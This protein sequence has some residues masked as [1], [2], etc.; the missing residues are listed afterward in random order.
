VTSNVE[1]AKVSGS[2]GARQ[3]GR[4]IWWLIIS[5]LF[6]VLLGTRFWLAKKLSAPKP[7]LALPAYTLTD[8][9]GKPFGAADLRGKAYIADFVFTSCPSVCPR[10]TKRMV[11]VQNRT[12]DLGDALYL[13]TFSVDPENDTPERLAEYARKYQ[14]N[15]ARWSFLTGPLGDVET[16]VVKGF[17]MVIGKTETS[18]GIF[19]IF[20]GERLVLVDGDGMIRAFYEADDPGIEAVVRD[21]H[22]IANR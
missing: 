22:L 11:E 5:L 6:A 17:K 12:A 1:T 20:H 8:Q 13:V 7:L 18:P 10:L 4:R 2:T 14:A 9:H 19:E 3:G 16:V 15:E 21:A